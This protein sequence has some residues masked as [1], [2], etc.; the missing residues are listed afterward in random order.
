MLLYVPYILHIL[1][2]IYQPKNTP[3]IIKLSVRH[4]SGWMEYFGGQMCTEFS[5]ISVGLISGSS[6]II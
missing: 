4:D 3:T 6:I 5:L 1:R 2:A